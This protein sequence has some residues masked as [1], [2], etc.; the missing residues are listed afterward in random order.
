MSRHITL[1]PLLGHARLAHCVVPANTAR[2]SATGTRRQHIWADGRVQSCQSRS[3]RLEQRCRP[4]TRLSAQA[5][6]DPAGS[7]SR[8]NFI[9]VAKQY[10]E[11]VWSEGNFEAMEQCMAEDHIQVD[12]VWIPQRELEGRDAMKRGIRGFRSA[13]P[14]LKFNVE[15]AVADV[16]ASKVF[17]YW[18]ASG[19]N[20]GPMFG[21]EPTGASLS[22]SGI[23]MLTI[24]LDGRIQRSDVYRE[25]TG[26]EKA[27]FV[28]TD[29]KGAGSDD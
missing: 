12:R 11:Q 14:D 18:T 13:Y 5:A 26:E 7:L 4:V 17:V 24:N 15:E 19:S 2:T 25:A 27:P 6:G 20:Q 8:E 3:N 21:Q 23:S 16:S 1:H 28:S 9:Q 10:Y 29:E 22:I